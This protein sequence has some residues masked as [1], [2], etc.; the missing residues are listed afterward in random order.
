VVEEATLQSLPKIDSAGFR[1]VGIARLNVSTE[2]GT[3]VVVGQPIIKL[4]TTPQGGDHIL[5]GQ[6][7]GLNTDR[8]YRIIT[9]VKPQSGG[10]IEFEAADRGSG[11]PLNYAEALFNLSSH[12]VLRGTGL[13]GTRG[14]EQ[15]P[16]GW[17]RVW[18][19]LKTS[20]GQI[21]VALRAVNGAATTFTGDGRLG[22]ILG[23]VRADPKG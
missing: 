14:I 20:T 19:D 8:A 1:W 4:I 7:N 3:S 5:A 15:E 13:A 18:L 23:G 16:D 17:E 9:W 22:L 6:F 11:Q 10:N 2:S 21:V 12:E